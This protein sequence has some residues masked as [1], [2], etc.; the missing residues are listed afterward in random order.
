LFP[1]VPTRRPPASTAGVMRNTMKRLIIFTLFIGLIYFHL[2]GQSVKVIL[3]YFPNSKQIREK[4]F[5]IKQSQDLRHGIY[6]LYYKINE[7]IYLKLQNKDSSTIKERGVYSYGF[8]VNNWNEY[9]PPKV[10]TDKVL[11]GPLKQKG[12]YIANLKSGIWIQ[13]KSNGEKSK[14][15]TFLFKPN[16][17]WMYGELYNYLVINKLNPKTECSVIVQYRLKEDCSIQDFKVIKSCGNGIDECLSEYFLRRF[18]L[19]GYVF[20][21]NSTYKDTITFKDY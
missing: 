16:E 1:S 7:S 14:V 12:Q 11:L 3:S 20:C 17:N 4:Y 13:Y 19:K 5:V 6:T 2:P 15:D 8:M 18:H 9:Y 10:T 21:N